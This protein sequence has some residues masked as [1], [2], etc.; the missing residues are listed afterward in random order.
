MCLQAANTSSFVQKFGGS[1]YMLKSDQWLKMLSCLFRFEVNMCNFV[2]A[3]HLLETCER[4]NLFYGYTVA[5][6]VS[7][8]SLSELYKV[9]SYIIVY[10]VLCLSQVVRSFPEVIIFVLYWCL[11]EKMVYFKEK[12]Q[13]KLIKQ[14]KAIKSKNRANKTQEAQKQTKIKQKKGKMRQSS[15]WPSWG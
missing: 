5:A 13:K 10:K 1:L 12:V 14:I 3:V 4:M 9:W 7:T 11:P 2:S 8:A 15:M 6:G